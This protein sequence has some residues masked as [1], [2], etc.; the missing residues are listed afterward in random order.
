MIVST[1]QIIKKIYYNY[2]SNLVLLLYK[3]RTR[4]TAPPPPG[5]DQIMNAL[6]ADANQMVGQIMRSLGV[7]ASQARS[8]LT[9]KFDLVVYL[10]TVE[11]LSRIK[12]CF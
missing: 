2:A 1:H 11:V 8:V 12:I 9:I 7:D 5:R 4:S 10:K 6:G 3:G